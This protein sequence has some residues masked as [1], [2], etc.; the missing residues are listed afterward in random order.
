MLLPIA[1]NV[2]YI[3]CYSINITLYLN[4]F[5]GKPAIPSLIGLSPL[6]TIH[7]SILLIHEFGPQRIKVLH[8]KN[9]NCQPDQG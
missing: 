9:A 3:L 4:R 2:L 1:D 7:L 8:T 5:R 6:A